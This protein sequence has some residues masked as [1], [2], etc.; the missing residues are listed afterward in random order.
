MMAEI[1][2]ALATIGVAPILII[3]VICLGITFGLLWAHFV[4]AR[5]LVRMRL[6]LKDTQ[7]VLKTDIV[8]LQMQ[9][10]KLK[11]QLENA[12]ETI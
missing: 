7:L 6:K 2:A 8:K 3:Q 9:V 10:N 4:L 11:T 1:G 5:S 12:Q